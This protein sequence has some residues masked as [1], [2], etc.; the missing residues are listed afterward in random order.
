M[1]IADSVY[2]S[3]WYDQNK[4]IKSLLYVMLMRAQRPALMTVGP[5]SPMTNE[6][7]LLVSA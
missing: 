3:Q 6:T 5:F 1:G 7:S 4:E 2:E